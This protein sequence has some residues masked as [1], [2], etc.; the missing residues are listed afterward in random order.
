M[1]TRHA[2]A[3]SAVLAAGCAPTTPAGKDAAAAAG[4]PAITLADCVSAVNAVKAGTIVKVEGKT[5]DGRHVYEFDVRSPDGTQWD[6][7]CDALTA[8]IV[9]VEQEVNAPTDTPFAAKVKIS[10]DSAKAIALAAYPGTVKEVEY[11]VE[12][13]GDATYE[14]DIVGADGTERKIEVDATRGNITEN[15]AEHYQIGVE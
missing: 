5:E 7:E 11:E 14:I 3:W 2:L 9:E 15:E 12:E 10:L 1:T 6:V 13:N 4:A 8:R